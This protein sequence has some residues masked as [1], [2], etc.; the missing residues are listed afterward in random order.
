MPSNPYDDIF[1]NLAR[2]ME[3][4]LK[5][6]PTQASSH[7]VHYTIIAEPGEAPRVFQESLEELEEVPYETIETEECIYITAEIES[8]D[9]EARVEIGPRSVTIWEKDGETTI[10]IE[11]DIDPDRSSYNIHHGIL[12]VVCYKE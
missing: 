9:G 5:Y 6:F 10:D 1:K 11:C 2:M 4:L 8:D 12:D 3:D 7:V